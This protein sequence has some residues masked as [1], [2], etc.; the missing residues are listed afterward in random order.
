[1]PTEPTSLTH[2]ASVTR[3]K[4]Q[5]G[6]QAICTCGWTAAKVHHSTHVCTP[7]EGACTDITGYW[8]GHEVAAL[9][10]TEDVYQ[11]LLDVE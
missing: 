8:R 10:A 3:P 2:E 11:H 4:D 5:T 6:H 9:A 7:A 1:M